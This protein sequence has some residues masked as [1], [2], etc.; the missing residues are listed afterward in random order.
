MWDDQILVY[1]QAAWRFTLAVIITQEKNPA[2][3]GST[4]SSDNQLRKACSVNEMTKA[5]RPATQST[6]NKTGLIHFTGRVN[7][8]SE[9]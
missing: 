6:G 2:E 5:G 3:N 1:D 7:A 9:F 8:A 4:P